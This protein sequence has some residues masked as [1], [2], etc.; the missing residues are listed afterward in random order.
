MKPQGIIVVALVAL[1]LTAVLIMVG[2]TGDEPEPLSNEEFIAQLRASEKTGDVPGDAPARAPSIEGQ[3]DRAAKI[4]VEANVY[5]LGLIANDTIAH[6]QLKVYNRGKVPLKIYRV[7][8]QCPCTMG[9]L[10]EEIEP[11]GEA[12]MEITVDPSLMQGF[13]S[14]KFLTIRNNDPVNQLFRVK[15]RATVD[16]EI[17]IEP[18]RLDFGIVEVGDTPERFIRIRQLADDDFTIS[19]IE[20]RGPEDTP[21]TV[22]HREVPEEDWAHPGKREYD[23][24]VAVSPTAGPGEHA[25][26]LY[27]YSDSYKRLKSFGIRVDMTVQ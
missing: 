6:G 21:F 25:I 5:D 7:D 13:Y 12:I 27:V 18:T 9:F 10:P 19:Y 2:M 16:P 26:G 15:V 8:T 20:P 3:E 14:E 11:G 4:E 23:V 17:A 22:D 24:S 1:L